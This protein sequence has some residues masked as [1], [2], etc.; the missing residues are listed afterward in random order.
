[1]KKYQIYYATEDSEEEHDEDQVRDRGQMRRKQ[2]RRVRFEVEE[3][4]TSSEEDRDEEEESQNGD[5]DSDGDRMEY[6]ETNRAWSEEEEE[7]SITNETETSPGFIP[8]TPRA[9]QNRAPLSHT[10]TKVKTFGFKH[11]SRV[12]GRIAQRGFKPQ[13]HVR[14]KD[15][16]L[17]E[18]FCGRGMGDK[19]GAYANHFGLKF[20]NSSS[21]YVFIYYK[22]GG[23][24]GAGS[25]ENA[26]KEKNTPPS[27]D[28]KKVPPVLCDKEPRIKTARQLTKEEMETVYIIKRNSSVVQDEELTTAEE[29]R[30]PFHRITAQIIRNG[31]YMDGTFY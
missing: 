1:M 3:E 11:D 23:E 31:K 30:Q 16:P 9:S 13:P 6:M 14:T 20:K 18:L 17:N 29:K 2:Q 25:W 12:F 10:S 8:P 7:E 24:K 22:K 5:N 26:Y 15:V 27:R 28:P 21:K 19:P 4:D